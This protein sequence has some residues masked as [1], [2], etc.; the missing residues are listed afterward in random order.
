MNKAWH[1]KHK[2]NWGKG[3]LFSLHTVVK[4]IVCMKENTKQWCLQKLLVTLPNQTKRMWN[5]SNLIN[6]FIKETKIPTHNRILVKMGVYTMQITVL[7]HTYTYIHT[8]V[9]YII[10][11]G[12]LKLAFNS[13][14]KTVFYLELA[15]SQKRKPTY[16]HISQSIFQ[17]K[18]K[19]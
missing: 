18:D 3:R 10:N 6:A 2:V 15:I 11:Y 1:S 13:S 19:H 4:T 12:H 8:L 17:V 14:F 16:C 7:I 5:L 9:H